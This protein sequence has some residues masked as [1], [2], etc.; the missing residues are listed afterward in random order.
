LSTKLSDIADLFLTQ[1]SDYRLVAIYQTSGS[2]VLNSY[3]EPWLM[4]SVV[5]FNVC[6]PPLVYT[7][8]S[9]SVEG[10]FSDDLTFENQSI[11][12][13]L[14]TLKWMQK[15]IQDILQM[16]NFVQ[17]HDFKGFSNANSLDKK[18]AN[19]NAKREEVSQTLVDYGYK[20]NPWKDWRNQIYAI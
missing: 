14:M 4:K 15:N 1:I 13:D 12:T 18:Q 8:T 9:G 19:Y 16:N 11:L 2:V 5:E 17:D 7:A 10:Y 3:M 20:N 6:V